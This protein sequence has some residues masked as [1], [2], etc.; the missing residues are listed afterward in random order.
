MDLK[1]VQMGDPADFFIGESLVGALRTLHQHTENTGLSG[2]P[3]DALVAPRMAGSGKLLVQIGPQG[4][5]LH[6]FFKG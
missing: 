6:F 4:P 1:S 5:T 2:F 3:Y